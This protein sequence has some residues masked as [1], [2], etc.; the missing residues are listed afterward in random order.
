MAEYFEQPEADEFTLLM[1][2]DDPEI[3]EGI[4]ALNFG[5]PVS[6]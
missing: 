6:K 4:L 2:V 3:P 5:F 1:P